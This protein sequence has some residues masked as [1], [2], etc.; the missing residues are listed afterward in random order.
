M[1]DREFI[2]SLK[3]GTSMSDDSEAEGEAGRVVTAEADGVRVEK[4]FE[5]DEFP[6]PVV[7]FVVSSTADDPVELR[8]TDQIPESFE[9]EHVGFHPDFDSEK[10]TAYRDHRVEFACTLEPGAEQRTVYGVRLDDEETIDDFLAEPTLERRDETSDSDPD[11]V[12]GRETN[13]L[14]REALAGDE[15]PGVDGSLA[16]GDDDVAAALDRM[17][18]VDETPGDDE[19]DADAGEDDEGADE[20]A[21]LSVDV[22]LDA[23]DGADGDDGADVTEDG[24]DGDDGADPA[25]RAVDEDL[26][27]ASVPADEDA[28]EDALVESV[29]SALAAELRAG[30]VDDDD[31][32]T[33]R[34]HLDVPGSEPAVPKSVDVRL[35]RVQSK[36]GELDAYTEALEEFLDENGTGEELV[37]GFRED[38]EALQD[39]VATLADDIAAVEATQSDLREEVDDVDAK[40]DERAEGLESTLAEQRTDFEDRL[41]DVDAAVDAVDD[42]VADLTERLDALESEVADVEAAEAEELESLESD[43]AELREEIASFREF[44]DRMKSAFGE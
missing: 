43:V 1:R 33:L 39:E 10:W 18:D 12:L 14:V 31:V 38:V 7:S 26:P 30:N 22:S 36:L 19:V 20:G 17:P 40:V 4:T 8:L 16:P 24:A 3:K 27:P 28:P 21:A 5:R 25:P 15:V 9:M 29:A 37:V 23:D 44:R 32:E 6:V 34:D 13:Q 35:R 42:D 41:A 11:D 2:S